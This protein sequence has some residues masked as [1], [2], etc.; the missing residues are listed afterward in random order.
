MFYDKADL[1]EFVAAIR[2]AEFAI[3]PGRRMIE[4]FV[5]TKVE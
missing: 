5:V 3:E 4:F 2:K 1:Q